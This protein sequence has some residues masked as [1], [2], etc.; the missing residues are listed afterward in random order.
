[1]TDRIA[2]PADV[3]ANVRRRWPGAAE[4]WAAQAETQLREICERYRATPREVLSARYGFVVAVDTAD[5]PL[6]I[7]SSPDPHGSDQAAVAVALAELSIAPRVHE[8]F[9]TE[10]GTWSVL[11]RVLPG[12]PLSRADPVTVTPHALFAPL[13]AMADQPPPVAGMPSILDWLRDRLE[14]DHLADLRPGTTVASVDERRDALEVLADLTCDH[15]P[16]LCHGDA[17]SGN[18][19]AYA[20]SRWMFIDPRGMTGEHSYDVAV[21]AL[22]VS[23]VFSSPDLTDLIAALAQTDNERLRAWMKIAQAARV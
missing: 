12:T 2:V 23:A 13:A 9:S 22:R 14:D 4:S 16:A 8:A 1:M 15:T 6:V 5:G 7:R 21:L 19:L 17:S 3:L 20:P 10:H 11:D 18:I